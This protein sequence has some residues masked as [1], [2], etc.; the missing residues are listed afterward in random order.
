MEE[1][2]A[3]DEWRVMWQLLVQH[4]PPLPPRGAFWLEAEGV[5]T[6]QPPTDE[7]KGKEN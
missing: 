1:G 2:R 3:R 5:R 6:G 4:S 7:R